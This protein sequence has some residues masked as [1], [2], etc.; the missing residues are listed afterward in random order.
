MPKLPHRVADFV[1]GFPAFDETLADLEAEWA[2]ET[3]PITTSMGEIG[4]AFVEGAGTRFSPE[5]AAVLLGRLEQILEEGTE[6]ERDAA[7]TGFLE[8]AAAT[9]DRLPT[10]RWVLDHAGPESLRYL[11]AWDRFCGFGDSATRSKTE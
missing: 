6:E 4:R 3:P 10:N 1:S 7:A 2:P 8:A 5:D 9:L 11:A